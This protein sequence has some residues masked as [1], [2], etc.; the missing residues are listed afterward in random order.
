M[1]SLEFRSAEWVRT[2][3][4]L[5][6]MNRRERAM[7]LLEEAIELAQAEG[8]E[9]WQVTSQSRHVYNRPPGKPDQEA[10]GVAVCLLAWCE[11][12]GN[13]LFEIAKAE[14][15]RIEAKPIEEIRG[16]LARKQDA[17]LVRGCDTAS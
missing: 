1:A 16:S 14:L 11:S 2:R 10:G 12:T 4:G 3:I 6:H 13:T 15:E 7:R 17:D 5:E 9:H 8:I